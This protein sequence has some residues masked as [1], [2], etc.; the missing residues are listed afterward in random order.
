MSPWFAQRYNDM[1][2][3]LLTPERCVYWDRHSL[4]YGPGL[5]HP[6]APGASDAEWLA[7]ARVIFQQAPTTH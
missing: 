5:Q 1:R 6:P 3:A 2:W 4:L 7:C